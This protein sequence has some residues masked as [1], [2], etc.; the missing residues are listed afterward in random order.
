MFDSPD[1]ALWHQEFPWEFE[2][3]SWMCLQQKERL[4]RGIHFAA[5]AQA[6]DV[7]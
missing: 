3:S 2:V 6:E 4:A 5:T 1:G 7:Q